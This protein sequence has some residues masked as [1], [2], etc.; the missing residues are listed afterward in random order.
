MTDQVREA[1]EKFAKGQ[2]GAYRLGKIEGFY[3][4][5]EVQDSWFSWQAAWAESRCALIVTLPESHND[6]LDKQVVQYAL[7]VA[8]VRYE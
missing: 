1:F 8:G 6:W 4:C 2:F 7:D 5:K 3:S